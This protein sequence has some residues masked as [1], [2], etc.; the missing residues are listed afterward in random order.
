MRSEIAIEAALTAD[1]AASDH[2]RPALGPLRYAAAAAARSDAG[3]SSTPADW[4]E[5][6]NR[7]PR[8][9]SVAGL[10]TRVLQRTAEDVMARAWAQVGEVT[11]ANAAL[12]RLQASRAVT[13]SLHARHLSALPPGQLLATARPVLPRARLDAAT[14]GGDQ[15]PDALAA[16]AASAL[17]AGT[18]WRGISAMARGQADRLV[19]SWLGG[20]DATVPTPDGTVSMALPSTVFGAVAAGQLLTDSVRTAAAAAQLAIDSTATPAAGLDDLVLRSTAVTSKASTTL[21]AQTGKAVLETALPS[22]AV[23]SVGS[24]GLLRYNELTAAAINVG[25]VAHAGATSVPIPAETAKTVLAA[26]LAATTT[27]HPAVVLSAAALKSAP[28]TKAP[29]SKPVD[30]PVSSPPHDRRAPPGHYDRYR[31]SPRRNARRLC[32][33]RRSLRPPGHS[34][35]AARR[36]TARPRRGPRRP[37]R[38]ARPGPDSRRA[39]VTDAFL[40][41]RPC[42]RPPTPSRRS[43]SARSSPKGRTPPW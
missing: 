11:E 22:K 12:R 28:T 34:D 19:G 8:L 13:A 26:N 40:P 14:T 42:S 4:F 43:W 1:S 24:G 9:R 3:T 17:P 33:G 35:A 27:Q 39:R 18:T 20:L 30:T 10:G 21:A 31:S 32:L 15:H 16:V 37:A 36:R 6:L 23:F 29:V 25:V 2:G 7:D 5:Q 38:S 41:S